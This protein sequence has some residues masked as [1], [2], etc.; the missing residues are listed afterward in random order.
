MKNTEKVTIIFS[1]LAF[2]LAMFF[3]YY[4]SML[5]FHR[6]LWKISDQS[7]QAPASD[8]TT[9]S[10]SA[11][12]DKQDSAGN[13]TNYL[14]REYR[15]NLKYPEFLNGVESRSPKSNNLIL[16]IAD[17]IQSSAILLKLE[18]AK[19]NN[20]VK[21]KDE[22]AAKLETFFESKSDDN[23]SKNYFYKYG[24]TAIKITF[25]R[26]NPTYT[27]QLAQNILNNFSWSQ[28]NSQ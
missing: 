20:L 1:I 18:A 15:F 17:K 23:E 8:R 4:F 13:W 7:L 12:D 26:D 22:S 27:D 10:P 3:V 24:D 21:V 16:N 11:K 14:N 9:P 28:E 2:S 25:Y 5:Y 19:N 6:P